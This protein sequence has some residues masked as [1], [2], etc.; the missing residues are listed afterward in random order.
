MPLLAFVALIVS[1]MGM[2]S[3]LPTFWALSTSMLAGVNVAV[4]IALI[5]SIG[6]VGGYAGPVAL[7]YL[8]EAT[9]GHANG[10]FYLA[11]VCALAGTLAVLVGRSATLASLR[12]PVGESLD[13]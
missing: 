13:R 11:A 2:Y 1:A 9:G 4:A 10:L 8:R 6:N 12:H 3:A 5:N 7:G